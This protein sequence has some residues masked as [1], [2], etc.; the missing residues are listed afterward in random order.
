M[1]HVSTH[2]S[3]AGDPLVPED[4]WV[5]CTGFCGPTTQWPHF[6]TGCT[7]RGG[8]G[9]GQTDRTAPGT[10]TITW[11][12]PFEGG[13]SLNLTNIQNQVVGTGTGCPISHPVEVQVSG[14][15]ADNQQYAGCPVTATICTNDTDF[16][17]KPGI[18]FV[19]HTVPG[20]SGEPNPA[21]EIS[22]P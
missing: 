17:L 18:L 16:I 13:Q 9:S 20:S 19:I 11:T 1:S 22:T 4:V 21:T 7:S 15:L 5:Q 12:A 14:T 2:P 8:E 10:E 3:A 6:L